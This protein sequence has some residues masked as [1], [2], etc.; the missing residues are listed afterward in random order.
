MVVTVEPLRKPSVGEAFC[1]PRN[2]CSLISGD[3]AGDGR[4][5]DLLAVLPLPDQ[6]HFLLVQCRIST[7]C[8]RRALD[9]SEER[10]GRGTRA[11]R[12]S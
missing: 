2:A 12:R 11:G 8:T 1:Q 9:M 6:M 4:V 3:P 5:G 10:G 7:R